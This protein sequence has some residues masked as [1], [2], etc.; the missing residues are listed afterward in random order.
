M[1]VIGFFFNFYNNLKHV[2]TKVLATSIKICPKHLGYN[3]FTQ[4]HSRKNEKPDIPR[5]YPHVYQSFLLLLAKTYR[6]GHTCLHLSVTL[7]EV[8]TLQSFRYSK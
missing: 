3:S 6:S 1:F 2:L 7:V 5:F 8:M 4:R